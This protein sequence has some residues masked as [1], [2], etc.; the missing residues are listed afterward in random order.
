[1]VVGTGGLVVVA[2]GVVVVTGAGV[3]NALTRPSMEA[4]FDS[5]AMMRDWRHA[6]VFAVHGG[7]YGTGGGVAAHAAPATT[8]DSP[9]RTRAQL[10]RRIRQPAA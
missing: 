1:V 9:A 8:R 6:S 5:R 3:S 2:A 10:R 4:A 7:V